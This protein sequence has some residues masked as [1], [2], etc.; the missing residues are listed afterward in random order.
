MKLASTA[1]DHAGDGVSK[2]VTSA[3]QCEA[4]G[5]KVKT[6]HAEHIWSKIFICFFSPISRCPLVT[7]YMQLRNLNY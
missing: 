2:D 4:S 6:V 7:L 1:D 5:A 3:A